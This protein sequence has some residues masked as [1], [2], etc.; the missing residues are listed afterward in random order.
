VLA[1]IF[2]IFVG[3]TV[4]TSSI[5]L[6]SSHLPPLQAALSTAPCSHLLGTPPV[7]RLPLSHQLSSCLLQDRS[8]KNTPTSYPSAPAAT[9]T[10]NQ[11][12]HQRQHQHQLTLPSS[13]RHSLARTHF[14]ISHVL[15]LSALVS[16]TRLRLAN[17]TDTLHPVT[18]TH[19][20]SPTLVRA[21]SYFANFIGVGINNSITAG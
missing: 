14:F 10:S 8:S 12:Q 11:R 5:S 21:R 13:W 7:S 15:C 20:P 18:R 16:I 1:F 6:S 2:P 19:T 3:S 4:C 9:S 17:V